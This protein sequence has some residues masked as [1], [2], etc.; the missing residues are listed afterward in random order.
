MLSR[1]SEPYPPYL[2]AKL[3]ALTLIFL[4]LVLQYVYEPHIAPKLEQW[5]TEFIAKREA[6][7][8]QRAGAIPISVSHRTDEDLSSRRRSKLS[9]SDD[10]GVEMRQSIE[11]ENLIAKEVREWRSEV[12][13]SQTRGLRHRNNAGPSGSR[14]A[15]DEVRSIIS[16]IS[17]SMS[18]QILPVYQ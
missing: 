7:R 1:R 8:R 9:D 18:D 3:L 12:N 14:H 6:R 5:A 4:F 17:C 13:R 15:L 2:S 11:L 16:S 10:E